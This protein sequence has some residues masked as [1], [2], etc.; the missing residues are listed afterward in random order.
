MWIENAIWALLGVIFGCFS[1]LL[2]N[3]V[4]G[5][6]FEYRAFLHHAM[7][8]DVL[9]KIES[10]ITAKLEAARDSAVDIYLRPEKVAWIQEFE[11]LRPN[12]LVFFRRQ[13]RI[14]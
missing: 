1:G 2:T 14:R 7:I 5:R 8:E 9:R 13:K 6:A 4:I 12:W 3:C 10:Q 11:S